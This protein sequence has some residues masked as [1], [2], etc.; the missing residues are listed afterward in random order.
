[1]GIRDNFKKGSVE[2]MILH[3]LSEKDMYGYEMTQLIN[4][5]SGGTIQVPEGS[6]YPTLYR[7]IDNGHVTD[8]RVLVGRRQTRVYYHIEP[9]GLVR[10]EEMRKEYDIFHNGLTGI[11]NYKGGDEHE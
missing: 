9:T 10:L 11:L 2:M 5:R 8:R 3:L 6:L 7:L 1:M 4:E